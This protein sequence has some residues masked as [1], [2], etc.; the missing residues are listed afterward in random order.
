MTTEL[1]NID[2]ELEQKILEQMKVLPSIEPNAEIKRRT[3]FIKRVLKQSGLRSLVLGIS[4][5]IDSCTCG[6]L[7]QLAIDELNQEAL[8]Q[9][10]KDTPYAFLAIRLPYAIQA[11]EKDAQLSLDFIQA[12]QNLTVNVKPATE[13]LHAEVLKALT[14]QGTLTNNPTQLDFAKG[15]V[16]ARMRMAAQYEVAGIVSGLVIGTDHSAENITGF[17]TKFGDG[18]CDLAPLFGL[19]K[20]Q[21]RLIAKTLGAPQALIDKVP[22]ADLESLTP[23]K[24]DEQALG[25]SYNDLDDFLE[26]K[27]LA[28]EL[29]SQIIKIY[30]STEH[31][32]QAILTIYD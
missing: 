22:T 9:G 18:A 17:F 5:G 16:K 27:P 28:T 19:N 10:N 32:R 24:P 29:K 8:T 11:D 14:E 6:R 1:A 13:G 26:G 3:D 2:T 4:G 21:V 20:R 23:A 7:A 25:I 30:T 12:S 15:N 31:K